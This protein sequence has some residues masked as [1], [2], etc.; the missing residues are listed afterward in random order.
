MCN[1]TAVK[2]LP[3]Q[4]DL[5]EFFDYDPETGDLSNRE[6]GHVYGSRKN[7]GVGRAKYILA[8][9]DGSRYFA[10]RVIWTMVNGQ[11][12]EGMTIDHINLDSRDNRISNLRLATTNQQQQNRRTWAKTGMKGI[13]VARNGSFY[14]MIS[15]CGKLMHLGT[16]YTLEE[17]AAEYEDAARKYQGQFARP[18]S[19]A[20]AA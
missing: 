13:Y 8:W 20:S 16:F 19:V 15:V 6:T 9:L 18:T 14:S 5:W 1:L 3:S 12:P 10:H 17:A 2:D 7:K 11:I 4:A